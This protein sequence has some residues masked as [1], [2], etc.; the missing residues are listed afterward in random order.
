VKP[1]TSRSA[2]RCAPKRPRSTAFM[3]LILLCTGLVGVAG[4]LAC[5]PRRLSSATQ[6]MRFAR[7]R[8]RV[9]TAAG[10]SRR[11]RPAR[12][13]FPETSHRM[14]HRLWSPS[15]RSRRQRMPEILAAHASFPFSSSAA[16]RGL[17]RIHAVPRHIRVSLCAGS[18]RRRW[19]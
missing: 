4:D 12:L 15:V 5:E 1:A 7:S 14:V 17:V 9:P 8:T 16:A 13:V 19:R 18:A 6:S 11:R 3:T 10:S 2:L